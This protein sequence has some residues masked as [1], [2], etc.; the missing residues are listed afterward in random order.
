VEYRREQARRQAEDEERAARA[1]LKRAIWAAVI[2]GLSFIAM[3][4]I[5]LNPALIRR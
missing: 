5:G 4:I 1:W 2:I 3:L